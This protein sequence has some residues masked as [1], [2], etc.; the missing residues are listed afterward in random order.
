MHNDKIR[1]VIVD[2]HPGVRAGIK[3]LL[4]RAND[5][6]VVGEGEDGMRALEVATTSKP[7]IVLL[8]VELPILGGDVVMHRLHE[9]LPEI[10]VLAVSTYSDA[11]YIQSML[12]NGAAGYITK[13]EAPSMLLEAIYSV[14]RDKELCW[15]SPK[16]FSNSGT[17]PP[18]EQ[19]L[20]KREIAILRQ[21]LLGQSEK[22]IA[23]SMQMGG[24]Q[25][26]S[27]LHL[28]MQKFDTDTLEGLEAAARRFIPVLGG[29]DKPSESSASRLSD[30]PSPLN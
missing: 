11:M 8:D 13:D 6:I 23:A 17:P 30:H 18:E 2:D 21:L 27:Y 29:N 14:Y 5:I 22:E 25:V 12:A 7:D 1:V 20:S 24:Q 19:T 9:M 10:R 3:N 28:L 4:Q 15:M 16:A 26:S